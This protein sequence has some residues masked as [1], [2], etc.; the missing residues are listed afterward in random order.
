MIEMHVGQHDGIDSVEADAPHGYPSL[1]LKKTKAITEKRIGEDTH[2]RHFGE[3][4]S[5]SDKCDFGF[6]AGIQAA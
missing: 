4:R 6:S 3:G 2:P 1:A 5:V